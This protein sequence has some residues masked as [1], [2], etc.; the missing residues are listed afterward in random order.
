M[1]FGRDLVVI[2]AKLTHPYAPVYTVTLTKPA[3]HL[4]T[5]TA[6][7]V[8]ENLLPLAAATPVSVSPAA[9]RGSRRRA[10][11]KFSSIH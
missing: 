5:S 1:K 7:G 6:K 9:K 11:N 4:P 8:Q 3:S 10:A 2:S